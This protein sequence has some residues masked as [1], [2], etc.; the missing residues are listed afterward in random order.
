MELLFTLKNIIEAAELVWRNRKANKVLAFYGNLGSGKTTL[1]HTLCNV[2]GIRNT[3]TSPTFSIINEYEFAESKIYHI[4]LYRLKN[5]GEAINAGVEECLYSGYYCFL[6]WP[7]KVE[8]IL[9]SDTMKI[10]LET[11]D[12]QTR[13]LTIEDK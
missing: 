4:D 9:P 2:V 1:I 5:S 6:E 11:I 8:E 7:E 10:F 13:R 12:A 3:V